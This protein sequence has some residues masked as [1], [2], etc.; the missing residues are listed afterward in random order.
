MSSI[1][2]SPISSMSESS[3]FLKPQFVT[4]QE[5]Q[6]LLPFRASE[7]VDS[8]SKHPMI[9]I[10]LDQGCL[11][12]PHKT[13]F[14]W[15]KGLDRAYYPGKITQRRPVQAPG[16]TTQELS[17][18]ILTFPGSLHKIPMRERGY[19]RPLLQLHGDG[20]THPGKVRSGPT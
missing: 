18:K 13:T 9:N 14:V 3:T 16:E 5:K 12:G 7:T 2:Y 10:V 1:S 4:T 8:D 11:T 6:Q 17:F 19:L 20:L 15:K